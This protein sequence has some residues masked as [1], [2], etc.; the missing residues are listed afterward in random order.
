MDKK[1]K[2][3][4]IDDDLLLG[5]TVTMALHE[6]GYEVMYQNSL[7]GAKAALSESH[8]DIIILDVE[9]GTGNGI[10]ATPQLKTLAPD[11]PILFVS[12]HADSKTAIQAIDAGGVSYLRKPFDVEELAA[13][14]E[15]FAKP[16]NYL[17]TISTLVLNTETRELLDKDA[18]VIKLLSESEYKLLKLLAAYPNETVNRTQIEKEIWTEGASSE[19][20]LNNF[21][22]KLRKYLVADPKLE[23]VAVQKEGYKLAIN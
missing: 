17:V 7:A 9:I 14:I 19:Q 20:S 13:Y 8:P 1:I 12:S 10:E 21:I 16:H 2:V 15:R 11:T 23:L 22:S 6:K 3:L 4:F 5:Y 18:K